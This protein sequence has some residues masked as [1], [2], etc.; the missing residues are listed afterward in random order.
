MHEF[1]RLLERCNHL[2]G[3]LPALRRE[4]PEPGDRME[5]FAA[6]A[7]PILEDANRSDGGHDH[8]LAWV[9]IQG[10]IDEMLIKAGWV[11]QHG[12]VLD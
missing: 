7:D 9:T 12:A 3:Q 8:C 4:Y 1:D 6:L 11:D 10:L 2:E 5:G